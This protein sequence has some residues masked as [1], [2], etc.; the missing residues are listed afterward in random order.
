MALAF[1]INKE[2]AGFDLGLYLADLR[3]GVADYTI[4]Y[5]TMRRPLWLLAF[6][7]ATH[8][9]APTRRPIV[10]RWVPL[11]ASKQQER[12]QQQQQPEAE[13]EAA[14]S[15]HPSRRAFVAAA[16]ASLA[17]PLFSDP[18]L[19]EEQ[20]FDYAAYF[21][22][23]SCGWWGLERVKGSN[24]CK[25]KNF[26]ESSRGITS[27]ALNSIGNPLGNGLFSGAGKKEAEPATAA[28]AKPAPRPFTEREQ[29]VFFGK[30]SAENK[31]A[32]GAM[33]GAMKAA[34][35]DTDVAA[36][37]APAAE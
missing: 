9:F 29:E 23:F 13:A 33:E 12:P 6:V 24:Q 3:H 2:E 37:A 31:A 28:A 16:A 17:L 11:A 32:E 4:L 21:G 8:S 35:A 25:D 34:A 22:P 30:A 7:T 26:K 1:L 5:Y 36:P 10:R 27:S 18:T 20:A 14:P 19:A 15:A